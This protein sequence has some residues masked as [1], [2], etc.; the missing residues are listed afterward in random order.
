MTR[1]DEAVQSTQSTSAT[2]WATFGARRGT[3][4]Q[5]VA[6]HIVERIGELG[7]QAGDEIP[8]EGELARAFGVSR[9][10][11]REAL[12]ILAAREMVVSHQGKQA[13]VSVPS[14]QVIGQLIMFRTRQRSFTVEQ[15]LDTREVLEE[16][17]VEAAARRARDGSADT[18]QAARLALEMEREVDDRDNFID[19]DVDFHRA[20]AVL[21]DNDLLLLLLDSLHDVLLNARRASYDGRSKRGGSH[22]RTVQAHQEILRAVERGDPKAAKAAMGA[23]LADTRADL[24]AIQSEL[25]R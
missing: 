24:D 20:L 8:S 6:I 13:R 14:Y 7:L 12:R 19:I 15:L 5:Q 25:F 10:V 22:A 2:R 11:V 21:A 16:A 17:L 4:G 23:H 1:K 3:L 9:L 18:V